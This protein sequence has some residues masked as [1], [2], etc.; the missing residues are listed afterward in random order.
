VSNL[1]SNN[2]FVQRRKVI[3]AGGL[4]EEIGEIIGRVAPIITITGQPFHDP[5]LVVVGAYPS[6]DRVRGPYYLLQIRVGQNVIDVALLRSFG[7]ACGYIIHGLTILGKH[8][9][10]KDLPW[11]STGLA[12]I[13]SDNGGVEVGEIVGAGGGGDVV[14]DVLAF[15]AVEVAVRG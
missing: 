8:L 5:C 3:W 6:V 9:G 13:G 12:V 15:V 1:G 14:D 11:K 10:V 4:G 2:G 7:P